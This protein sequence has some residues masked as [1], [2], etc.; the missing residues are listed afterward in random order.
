MRKMILSAGVLAAATLASVPASAVVID[1]DT[2]PSTGWT[3]ADYVEDGYKISSTVNTSS[4]LS[5]KAITGANSIDP[6]GVSVTTGSGGSTSVTVSRLDG[7]AFGFGSMDFG[8]LALGSLQI[9]YKF[10]FFMADES[11]D[12]VKYFSFTNKNMTAHTVEFADLGA[13]TGFRFGTSVGGSQ[14]FDNI[15]L[16]DVAAAVPEPATWAMMLGGFGLIGG[17]MRRRRAS[18]QFA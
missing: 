1:F 15:V 14:Q 9:A 2:I 12:I 5:F 3:Q 6:D 17:A 13:I 11:A 7:G 10:T 8:P 18:V 4:G 16:N